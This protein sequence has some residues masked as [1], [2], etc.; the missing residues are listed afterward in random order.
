MEPENIRFGGGASSTIL[1]P[2][3]AL[4][5]AVAVILIL[6]LPRKYVVVP[7][8]A[9]IFTIPIGQVLLVGGL[10]FMMAR[11]LVLAGL[12]RRAIT[13]ESGPG[14]VPVA[15]SKSV[16][17]AYTLCAVC[18][19][20]AFSLQWRETQA[21]IKAMA[22][23]IDALG[24]YFVLRFFIR[25]L[26]DVRRTIRVFAHLSVILAVCMMI[27]Q[28]AHLNV[29]GLLGGTPVVPAMREGDVRSAGPFEEYITAGVFGAT[30]VPLF[31]WLW[32]DGKNKAAA[33]WGMMGATI[34]SVT[35]NSSTTLMGLNAVVV[36][37]L[38]W[39]LRNQMRII[40]WALVFTL[41]SLHLVMKAPVWALIARVDLTGS[42]SSF[43]RYAL[44][45]NCIRHFSD[46]WLWGYKNYNDWGWD[47]WDL[48]NQYVTYALT[49]GLFTLA[50]FVALIVRG[51]RALGT[52]RRLVQGDRKKQWLL[53]CFSTA[54]FSHVIASFGI[55]YFDQ[56]QYA[57][58]TLLAMI[59]VVAAQ[60][61]AEAV[62]R[63]E[64]PAGRG[65]ETARAGAGAWPQAHQWS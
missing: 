35:S 56:M 18:L 30:L 55:G 20:V 43:H 1:H 4:W 51:F 28:V 60:P 13:K 63:A 8:L 53:W 39:P 27:E 15:E 37:F 33:A 44:I 26:D 36:G 29:F 61:L 21:F 34:I 59:C 23:F 38:F 58:Y 42:S 32:G 50:A 54:L 14:V 45:D 6:A 57:W 5:V 24:G 65:L 41:V 64:V 52:A 47:M 48:S 22:S 11:I 40:R 16:D 7:F 62:R 19:L 46:W 31:V 12:L 25:D 2:L 3:V 9:A 49:G 17:H 10:H